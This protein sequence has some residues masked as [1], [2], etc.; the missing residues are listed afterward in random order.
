M[1]KNHQM[2][3]KMANIDYRGPGRWIRTLRA[4][5]VAEEYSSEDSGIEEREAGIERLTF[6][7]KGLNDDIDRSPKCQH[8]CDGLGRGRR[9]T[10]VIF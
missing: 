10:I 8:P 9:I 1:A 5:N 6:G 2:T 3:P 4:E 7:M